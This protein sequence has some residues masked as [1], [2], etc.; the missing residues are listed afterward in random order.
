MAFQSSFK[1]AFLLAFVGAVL[2]ACDG[3]VAAPAGSSSSSTSSSSG[4]GGEAPTLG[5]SPSVRAFYMSRAVISPPDTK[6]AL[7]ASYDMQAL[8]LDLDPAIEQKREEYVPDWTVHVYEKIW[9]QYAGF[10]FAPSPDKLSPDEAAN[11]SVTFDAAASDTISTYPAQP[12]DADWAT[13]AAGFL[14]AENSVDHPASWDGTRGPMLTGALK[15]AKVG[16]IKAGAKNI[17]EALKSIAV[18]GGLLYPEEDKAF[19]D[20]ITMK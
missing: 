1:L 10:T 9:A 5:E 4:T 18:P 6:T 17:D 7:K 12:W 15:C 13:F 14:A 11:A 8:A 3:G 16:A 20:L 19:S 2:V